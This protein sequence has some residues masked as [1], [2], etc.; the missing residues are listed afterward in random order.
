MNDEIKPHIEILKN[1][2]DNTA[3]LMLRIGFERLSTIDVHYS[4]KENVLFPM[5]EKHDITAPPKVMWGKHD[6]IRELLHGSL[7][8]LKTKEISKDD[9]ISSA[10]LI[11]QPALKG[12]DEM[13]IKEE[14]IL[15][16]MLMDSL[17]DADWYEIQKQLT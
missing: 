9:L 2:F 4:R 3:V 5:L 7:E 13:I 12:V 16:P 15:F 14:E 6:E 17:S 1:G 11:L 10:E 8:I